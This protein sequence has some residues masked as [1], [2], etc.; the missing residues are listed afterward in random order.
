MP[1]WNIKFHE[2]RAFIKIFDQKF[3]VI[4]SDV[5]V[6]RYCKYKKLTILSKLIWIN[7]WR[8]NISNN[9]IVF[10][11]KKSKKISKKIYENKNSEWKFKKSKKNRKKIKKVF[12]K[13]FFEKI[14]ERNISKNIFK[15]IKL[16]ISRMIYTEVYFY[17]NSK[18]TI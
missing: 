5:R 11:K 16:L 15:I 2:M 1:Q 14:F 6:M 17:I 13:C 12:E 9:K 8:L 18:G 3:R 4:K 7:F 10:W